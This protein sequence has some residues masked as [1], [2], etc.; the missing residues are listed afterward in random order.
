MDEH[1]SSEHRVLDAGCA[2]GWLSQYIP[3]PYTGVDQTPAL[4]EYG[5]ELY[6]GINLVEAELQNLPFDDDSFDWVVCSCVKYGIVE[7]E[8]NGLMPKGRWNKIEKEFLRVSKGAI[9][10]PSYQDDFEI[11]TR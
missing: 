7:C 6:P 4:L 11:I 9:I 8:E 5:R 10:W 3:N 2:F 1:I